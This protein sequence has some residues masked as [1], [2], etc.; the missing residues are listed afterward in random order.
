MTTGRLAAET[1]IE[2][3]AEGKPFTAANLA[4]YRGKLDGSFV[5]KDLR[6]IATCP[7]FWKTTTSS[8]RSTRSWSTAPPTPC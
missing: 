1:A 8:L 5:M 2:L 6:N 4:R 3:R 7:R